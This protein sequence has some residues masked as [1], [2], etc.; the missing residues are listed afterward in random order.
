MV[1]VLLL[2][3]AKAYP[4]RVKLFS[5]ISNYREEKDDPVTPCPGN[6]ITAVDQ[7]KNNTATSRLEVRCNGRRTDVSL[8]NDV[9]LTSE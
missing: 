9:Q 5:L 8:T 7:S 1:V 6:L 4:K 3:G 2:G